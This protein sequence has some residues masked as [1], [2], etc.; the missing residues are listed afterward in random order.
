[1]AEI[2]WSKNQLQA[3]EE[4]KKNILVSAAA[5]SGKTAVLVERITQKIVKNKIDIDKLL[6]VTFTNAAASEIKMR[7]LE[8]I[9][10]KLDN[11]PS[12]EHLQK[13][14]VLLNRASICTIHSFCLDVI[15]NNFFE[16][17]VSS[18]FKVG[19][20]SELMLLKI[21]AMDDLFE[22]LYE[23]QD[24]DFLKLIDNYATYRTDENLRDL[25]LKLY[26][27]IQSNPFPQE[28]LD[29]QVEKFN[30]KNNLKND[31]STTIWGKILLEEIAENIEN[32]IA[33][34]KII[35]E[36]LAKDSSLL[37]FYDCIISDVSKLEE[38]RSILISWDK[39]YEVL[40]ELNFQKWPTDKKCVSSLKEE[41]KQKRD[42]I[43]KRFNKVRDRFIVCNSKEANE[44]I[45][46]MYS[47]LVKMKDLVF[48]FDEKYTEKKKEKNIIDFNDIEHYALKILVEQDGN[49]HIPTHVAKN[50]MNKFEE[51]A[52]DEYQDSNLVQET[53]L[54]AVSN[55]KNM[56]MVGDV[57]QSIYKFRQAKPELFITKYNKYKT[58]E[59]LLSIDTKCDEVDSYVVK[60]NG[61]YKYKTEEKRYENLKIQLFNN[62][63]SRENIV[64]FVNFVFESIMSKKLGDIDYTK[65]EFLNYTANFPEPDKKA[66]YSCKQCRGELC[67]PEIDYS[68]KQCNGGFTYPLETNYAG[69]ISIEIIDGKRR[70]EVRCLKWKAGTRRRKMKRQ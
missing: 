48:K 45:Y 39:T 30:L 8:A 19:D 24:Q 53:I 7:V 55:G 61:E 57:K 50:Y 37:K 2:K 4:E 26:E 60:E 67:S 14:I 31:F 29:E 25:V 43:K 64:D 16:I 3:I 49:T 9:Y 11:D 54:S 6:V 40:S 58:K 15:R 27:Y 17:G 47:I 13:Q 56:F 23:S 59:D 69:K 5:G 44:D 70:A 33:E 38:V 52:I 63:R 46:S 32:N 28:W 41:A 21:E 20:I 1:M 42:V 65:E 35:S 51:I 36:Q 22:E 34:L 18:D 66:D 68:D 62:F 10:D 12:N